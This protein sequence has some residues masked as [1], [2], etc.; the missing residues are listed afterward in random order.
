MPIYKIYIYE[1]VYIANN[2][3]NY[4]LCNHAILK[5]QI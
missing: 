4:L 3:S 2:K 5:Q 1:S